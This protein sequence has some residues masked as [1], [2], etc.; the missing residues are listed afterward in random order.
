MVKVNLKGQK[1]KK[2]NKKIMKKKQIANKGVKSDDKNVVVPRI[3]TN[4]ADARSLMMAR[5]IMGGMMP[6]P[7]RVYKA[8]PGAIPPFQLHSQKHYFQHSHNPF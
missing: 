8:K 7:E 5:G 6:A 1:G 2:V 3:P 4:M